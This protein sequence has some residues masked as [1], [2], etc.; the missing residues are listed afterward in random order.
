MADQLLQIENL[1]TF[2]FGEGGVA[3]AV[4]GVTFSIAGGE[5]IGLVGESGCGKSVTALSVLRL[6]RPPG[7]IQAGRR[8]LFEGGGLGSLGG[9]E[10]RARPRAALGPGVQ[11]AVDAPKSR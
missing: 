3:R 6:G 4:D 11:E 5:T 1:R 7:R 8:L 10:L 9:Q 2:F